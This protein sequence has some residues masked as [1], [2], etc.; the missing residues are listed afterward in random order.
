MPP[1]GVCMRGGQ[2]V[3]P[4]SAV[5]LT[6]VRPRHPL[7]SVVTTAKSQGLDAR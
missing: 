7:V 5:A 4:V 3:C 6:D 1:V 2:L